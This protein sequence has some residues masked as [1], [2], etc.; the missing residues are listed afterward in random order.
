MTQQPETAILP[1]EATLETIRE[2][3][4]QLVSQ[5]SKD[6]ALEYQ[7]YTAWEHIRTAVVLLKKV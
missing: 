5:C 6:P 7:V 4:Y 2:Q 3:L 1:V